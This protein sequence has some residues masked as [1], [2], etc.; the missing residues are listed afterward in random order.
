MGGSSVTATFTMPAAAEKAAAAPDLFHTVCCLDEDAAF[1]GSDVAGMPF[2][3]G[4]NEIRCV[5]CEDVEQH[6]DATG[7]CPIDNRRCPE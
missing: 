1:C 6:C 4:T 2:S 5:V 3:E 7:V